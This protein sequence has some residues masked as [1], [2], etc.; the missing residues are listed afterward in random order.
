MV[1]LT[2]L[3]HCT[4]HTV[5]GPGRYSLSTCDVLGSAPQHDG[6]AQHSLSTTEHGGP[7]GTTTKV[8]WQRRV[9]RWWRRVWR[10]PEP[11]SAE[12]EEEAAEAAMATKRGGTKEMIGAE[13]PS[14]A[15][16]LSGTTELN[17]A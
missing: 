11:P 13:E 7:V 10:R 5:A 4:S 3:R 9:Q 16:C 15:R 2:R 14:V 1:L 12:T 8:A 17:S 6:P